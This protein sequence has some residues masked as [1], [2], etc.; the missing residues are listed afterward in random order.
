MFESWSSNPYEDYKISTDLTEVKNKLNNVFFVQLFQMLK[1]VQNKCNDLIDNYNN[2]NINSLGNLRD[3]VREIKT[4]CIKALD[5]L[6]E[7]LNIKDIVN[8]VEIFKD[9]D[10]DRILLFQFG[11]Q[12]LNLFLVVSDDD[13][14]FVDAFIHQVLHHSLKQ[15]HSIDFKQWFWFFFCKGHQ[16]CTHASR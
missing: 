10:V 3:S 2:M 11:A 14:E 4:G 1:D 13:N 8:D 12:F 15:C 7:R 9:F 16:S 5:E 6:K